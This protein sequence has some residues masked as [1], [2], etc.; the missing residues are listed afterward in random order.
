[1]KTVWILYMLACPN[2]EWE[3]VKTTK[4]ECYDAWEC[5]PGEW[6]EITTIGHKRLSGCMTTMRR[7]K[8]LRQ[9]IGAWF[10][11]TKYECRKETTKEGLI[12]Q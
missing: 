12:Q 9:A 5:K 6:Y 11:Y 2:C 8:L 7:E 4:A 1:M 3:I 10:D